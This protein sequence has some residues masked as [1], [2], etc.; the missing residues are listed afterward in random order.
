[1]KR[2]LFIGF[3]FFCLFPLALLSQSDCALT[4]TNRLWFAQMP[5]NDSVCLDFNFRML[6]KDQKPQLE[7]YNAEETFLVDELTMA[8]DSI[9]FK[10]P[11]FD[12]ELRF[13]WINKDSISGVWIN[14]GSKN[15]SGLKFAAR[16]I[17]VFPKKRNL[18]IS[19]FVGKWKVDFNPENKSD[20]YKSIGLFKE[21][22][23]LDRIYGTFLTETGDYRYLS[24]RMY[25]KNKDTLMELSSFDG[26]HAYVFKAK[27]KV[28]K[29]LEGDFYSGAHG[30]ERW[31]AERNNQFELRNADSLTYLKPGYDKLDFSFPG[32]DGKVVSVSD[33][34]YRGK[35]VIVQIMGSWCPNCMDET[36]FLSGFYERNVS[37]GLEI[38]AL[39]Y[40]RTGDMNK[41]VANVERLKKR[42]AC[43][44]DFLIAA[45]SSDKSEAVKTLPALKQLISFPTTIYIDRK[46]KVRKIS[47]GFSGPATGTYFDK[48][49]KETNEFV[50]M[51]LK[52]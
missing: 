18:L 46:G 22:G 17:E 42:F 45:T 6:S 50:D 37:K 10:M 26:S 47:T 3:F 25:E 28:D 34:K 29:T 4:K 31:A 39:A 16:Q 24:G 2:R 38:V 13:K 7:I 21:S 9:G 30:H 33:D 8:S 35:V 41:A 44:Y 12:S 52:E 15:K 14:H 36:R 1:M 32:L 40:E 23:C 49:V 51:L 43:S 20:S 27:L 11:V 48:Y 19:P 5:L